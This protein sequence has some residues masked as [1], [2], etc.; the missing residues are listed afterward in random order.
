M[1]EN[2][3]VGWHHR[4]EF[5]QAPGVGEGLENLACCS[6]WSCKELDTT[7]R[8]NNRD[9]HQVTDLQ[10]SAG[11]CTTHHQ[12]KGE[13]SVNYKVQYEKLCL[14][15]LAA[16]PLRLRLCCSL[17]HPQHSCLCVCAMCSVM[18]DSL[19]LHGLQTTR[20]LCHGIFHKM[21]FS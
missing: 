10:H 9:D 7:E 11:Q 18:S 14:P 3:M 19:Q 13:N 1:T 8:L 12:C 15:L 16:L 2:E 17:C 21:L 6:P 5:E 20:V 4:L